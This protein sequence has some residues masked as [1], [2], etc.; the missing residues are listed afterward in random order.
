MISYCGT[1]RTCYLEFLQHPRQCFSLVYFD[2]E[3]SS[4]LQPYPRGQL[5][6]DVICGC[7]NKS[8]THQSQLYLSTVDRTCCFQPTSSAK[9]V[10]R[11]S[12]WGCLPPDFLKRVTEIE[13]L[14]IYTV[15]G[16]TRA[17]Y[18]RRHNESSGI[19][20]RACQWVNPPFFPFSRHVQ[21][22]PPRPN[23]YPV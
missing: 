22:N 12:S 11:G 14:Q 9:Y 13:S 21:V 10:L 7:A 18:S 16:M 20:T 5:A 23:R 6:V 3:I 4:A 1:D 2:A 8:M 17:V 15:H 19:I